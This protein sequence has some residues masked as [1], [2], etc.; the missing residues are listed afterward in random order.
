MTGGELFDLITSIG[1]E[2]EVRKLAIE[3][4]KNWP[5][6]KEIYK[7]TMPTRE[8]CDMIAEKYELVGVC[9]NGDRIL[10]VDKENE[11]ALWKLLKTIDR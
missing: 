11:E 7:T 1:Q 3:S 5:I 10:L 6:K 9:S 2:C 4:M 8:V